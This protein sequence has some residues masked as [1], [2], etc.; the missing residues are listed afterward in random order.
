MAVIDIGPGATDRASTFNFKY[1]WIGLNNPANDSGVL[2]TIEVYAVNN[3]IKE[4]KVG[5]FSQRDTNKFTNRDYESLGTV[6]YGSKQTFTGLNCDVVSGD[7]LGIFYTDGQVE[8]DLTGFAGVY[9][10]S[11]NILS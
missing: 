9:Y 1:T 3:N 11:S 6:T 8:R 7:Y 4:T 5:T 10:Y 2:D